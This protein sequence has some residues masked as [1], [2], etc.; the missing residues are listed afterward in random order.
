MNRISLTPYYDAALHHMNRWVHGGEPP[1]KQPLIEFAGDP[2][3]VARDS[4]GIAKGGIRLPQV[5]APVATNSAIPLE[6]TRGMVLRGSSRPF[7]AEELAALYRD[8]ADY[9]AKFEAA[10][11]RAV[12]VGVMLPRD[13]APAVAE[14]A[15]EYRRALSYRPAPAAERKLAAGP[16]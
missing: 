16:A 5:E 14:A 1:P 11:H 13:V 8:E 6:P 4:H 12:K 3:D 9:L 2:P 10:A 15:Q 7:D